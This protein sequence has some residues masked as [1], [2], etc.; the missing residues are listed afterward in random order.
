MT[1][2]LCHCYI[3][4][5]T[6]SS[7]RWFANKQTHYPSCTAQ[8]IPFIRKSSLKEERLNSFF[9]THSQTWTLSTPFHTQHSLLFPGFPP[10]G[11]RFSLQA[12]VSPNKQ[13]GITLKLNTFMCIQWMWIFFCSLALVGKKSPHLL[14]IGNFLHLFSKY[15]YYIWTF[16]YIKNVYT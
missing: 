16:L 13:H 11:M 7:L 1:L 8:V 5:T 14:L 15:A 9:C 4:T 10:T 6:P 12:H 3:Q 2:S